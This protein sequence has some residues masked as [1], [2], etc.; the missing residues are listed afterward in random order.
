MSFTPN[1]PKVLFHAVKIQHFYAMVEITK[2]HQRN[3]DRGPVIKF[4]KLYA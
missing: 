2:G 4:V 3:E 1:F